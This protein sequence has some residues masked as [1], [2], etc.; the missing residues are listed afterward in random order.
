MNLRHQFNFLLVI[1]SIH[2]ISCEKGKSFFIDDDDSSEYKH[3]F[4]S[5]YKKPSSWSVEFPSDKHGGHGSSYEDD[6]DHHK[7]Y[8]FKKPYKSDLLF[9]KPYKKPYDDEYE[10][11]EYEPHKYDDEE[12]EHHDYDHHHFKRPPHE[13]EYNF[14]DF[15][16]RPTSVSHSTTTSKP[17]NYDSTY[18]PVLFTE[19]NNKYNINKPNKPTKSNK[20]NRPNRPNKQHSNE[21]PTYTTNK[22]YPINANEYSNMKITCY[23]REHTCTPQAK[24]PLTRF[25]DLDS[26]MRC[27]L[28]NQPDFGVCCPPP[29]Y[30]MQRQPSDND[31]LPISRK[32]TKLVYPKTIKYFPNANKNQF[33]TMN[34][35]YDERVKYVK[36][37]ER[38]LIA[39]KLVPNKNSPEMAHH[40]F[41]G[42]NKEA[43]RLGA[44]G[45]SSIHK[46]IEIAK[47]YFHKSRPTSVHETMS[48]T[49]V[50]VKIANTTECP[51]QPVCSL[52][53]Y[54]TPDGTCNNLLYRNWGR[55]FSPYNRVLNPNYGDGINS[56]RLSKAKEELPNARRLSVDL[57]IHQ[58]PP[59]SKLSLVAMQFGQFIDHDM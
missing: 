2:L 56:P 37:I 42:Y 44:K 27:T 11:H 30:P 13:I 1:C 9:N 47:T 49:N 24:C 19:Y 38:A 32:A 39:K 33:R 35:N 45:E 53:K 41:F 34:D 59:E 51:K 6:D 22:P 10:S 43:I 8:S 57:T 23:D 55:A 52:S 25:D 12:N 7:P 18:K 17:S 14:D 54:R 31:E 28:P 29:E 16:R 20:S 5:A 36:Q 48:P 40:N 46:A 3:D 50:D 15:N 58:R 21:H 4:P 26:I